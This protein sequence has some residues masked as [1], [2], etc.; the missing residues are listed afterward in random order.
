M[1]PV[2]ALRL[3]GKKDIR[4]DNIDPIPCGTDEVRLKIAYCGICGTDIHEYL[5]SPIFAPAPGSVNEFTNVGLPVVLGHEMSGTIVEVG[6]DVH[7]LQ[8]GQSVSVSPALDDR[9]YGLPS[10]SR[11]HDNKLNICKSYASY[12]LNAEGG[13]FADE[14]VVS[15]YNVFALP[16]GVSLK[17]GALAE[18]LAVAW[19]CIR[20]SGFEAG[21]NALIMGAGPIGLAILLLLRVWDADKIII[22]EIAE[23]RALQAKKFGADVVVDPLGKPSNG[24]TSGETVSPIMEAVHQFTEDGVDVSFDTTGLQSNLDAGLAALKAGG[25]FYNVAIHEKPLQLNLNDVGFLEKNLMGGI[26]YTPE[27]FDQVITAMATGKIPFEQMITSVVPL[28]NVIEGGFME[29]M[30]NRSAHVKILIQPDQV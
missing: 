23:Q 29:L 19:H 20:T 15:K 8:I 1:G 14:I 22:T 2:K 9:H 16:A 28:S 13:G 18:P 3:Y 5:A 12:G 7:E 26:C 24:V 6:S 30:N 11:C 4:V 27:D 25:A 21:Q 17:I 10:C